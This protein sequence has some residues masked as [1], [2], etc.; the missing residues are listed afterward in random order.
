MALNDLWKNFAKT[1]NIQYYI[2]YKRLMNNKEQDN[3][4]NVS[5][6]GDKSDRRGGERPPFNTFN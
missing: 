6:V 4:N 2:E 5:S 1:G 3:A